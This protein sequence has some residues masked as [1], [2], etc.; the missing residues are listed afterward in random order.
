MLNSFFY[1]YS[2]SVSPELT[3]RGVRRRPVQPAW[4][5]RSQHVA[6]F[7]PGLT[8]TAGQQGV[9]WYGFHASQHR[10]PELVPRS[11]SGLFLGLSRGFQR[12]RSFG[13]LPGLLFMQ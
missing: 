10:L 6:E 11:S 2:I 7:P 12:C 5:S 8:I 3:N 13:F 9:A 4:L 1:L